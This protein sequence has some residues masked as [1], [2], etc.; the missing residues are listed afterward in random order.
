MVVGARRREG[1]LDADR[2]GWAGR[3][4]ARFFAGADVRGSADAG[5]GGGVA[6]L[7]ES[8][9][10]GGCG[11]G[12]FPAVRA[13]LAG[14]RGGGGGRAGH[15]DWGVPDCVPDADGL[16]DERG[17]GERTERR[18][19]CAGD[20]LG[21]HLSGGCAASAG[22]AAAFD[23]G[24]DAGV[25]VGGAGAAGRG[26]SDAA[27]RSG[28][29]RGCAAWFPSTADAGAGG[30]AGAGDD[31]AGRGGGRRGGAELVRSGAGGLE[32]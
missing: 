20:R 29:I 16:R 14:E 24:G 17:D 9:D 4:G 1:G 11:A 32:P 2:A 13:A 12:Q 8:V 7:R 31:S 23:A 28:A 22:A 3:A 25:R 10:A 30:R 5:A 27:G 21:R 18:S 19:L 26:V 15:R 6:G